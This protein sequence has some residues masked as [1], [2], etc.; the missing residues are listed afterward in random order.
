MSTLLLSPAEVVWS[1]TAD[2]L[3]IKFV[4]VEIHFCFYVPTRCGHFAES[5]TYTVCCNGHLLTRFLHF[6]IILEVGLK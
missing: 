3:C 1:S 5:E 6:N 4:P 2:D